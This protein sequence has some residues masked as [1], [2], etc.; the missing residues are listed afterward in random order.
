MCRWLVAFSCLLFV[1][2]AS[3][4]VPAPVGDRSQRPVRIPAYHTVRMGDTLY[5]ISWQYGLDVGQVAAWNGLAPPYRI[6]KG[7][8]LRLRAP[9]TKPVRKA[10]KPAPRASLPKP[11]RVAP[12]RPKTDASSG[13]A[14]A[15]APK[16]KMA[17]AQKPREPVPGGKP[18][19]RWPADG[20]LISRFDAGRPGRKGIDIAGRPGDPVRAAAD[21]K[22]VYA[23]SGLAGYGRLI[24]IKH[25]QFFLSAYAHNQKLIAR[26]GQWVKAGR[27]IARMGSSG[28]DRTRL[29]FEIRKNG[30]PVD[31][32][33]Y[34][35]KR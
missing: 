27:L 20:R 35:P 13:A 10:A 19:W 21:G 3:Q 34:L 6:V 7:Q 25:N 15:P 2:C 5:S 12:S 14:A 9:D 16:P 17:P 11:R 18:R 1:A 26:E 24:I 22:V 28:T 29:H 4:P 8:R 32:L 33:R 23:G 30:L 31:P